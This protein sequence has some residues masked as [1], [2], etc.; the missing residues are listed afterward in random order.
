MPPAE[1]ETEHYRHHQA[2]HQPMRQFR[3]SAETARDIL[4]AADR[5]LYEAKQRKRAA[6]S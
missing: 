1:Y 6:H 5:A 3:A 2:P 4:A